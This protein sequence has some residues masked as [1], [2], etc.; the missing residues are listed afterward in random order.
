[1]TSPYLLFAISPAITVDRAG[2]VS[3]PVSVYAGPEI[4]LPDCVAVALVCMRQSGMV[5]VWPGA[6]ATLS[7]APVPGTGPALAEVPG[8]SRAR[9]TAATTRVGSGRLRS[10]SL[11]DASGRR[12]FGVS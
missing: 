5:E 11:L 1:M 9:P 10:M 4:T 2:T 3:Q 12:R 7:A 8:T 6:A